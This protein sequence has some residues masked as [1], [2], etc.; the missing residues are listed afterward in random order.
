MN[1]LRWCSKCDDREW[2]D[3]ITA[4]EAR[5][6]YRL[7]AAEI[8]QRAWREFGLPLVRLRYG[9]RVFRGACEVVYAR[10]DMVAFMRVNRALFEQDV[11][12]VGGVHINM[13][14]IWPR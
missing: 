11:S 8:P 7:F 13:K 6:Q 14:G 2:P 12:R 5:K 10:E 1:G 4:L 3:R 9:T